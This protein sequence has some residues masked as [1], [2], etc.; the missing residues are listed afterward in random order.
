LSKEIN[1][2]SQ[3]IITSLPFIRHTSTTPEERNLKFNE[4]IYAV[5]KIKD[6]VLESDNDYIF[7]TLEEGLLDNLSDETLNYINGKSLRSIILNIRTNP[8]E[9]LPIIFE[10]LQD[11]NI[12]SKLIS[13]NVLPANYLL[14]IDLD[15]INSVYKGLF[16]RTNPSSLVSIQESSGMKGINYYAFIA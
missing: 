6:I 3:A 5:C 1:N 13:E 10:L 15:I 7:T 14:D 12:K 11:E 4:F 2:I 8:Q 9:V 16:D